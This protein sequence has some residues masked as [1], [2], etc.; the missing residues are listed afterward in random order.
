MPAA[1]TK[2]YPYPVGTDR[3]MD[4]DDAIK[5]LAQ[6]VDDNLKAGIASGVATAA[7]NGTTDGTPLGVTLPAGRFT[8]A[9]NVVVCVSAGGAG[10]WATNSGPTTTSFSIVLHTRSADSSSWPVTWIAVGV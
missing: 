3:V 6:K 10:L 5:N 9:P 4:G 1:T 7:M 8:V 2:G